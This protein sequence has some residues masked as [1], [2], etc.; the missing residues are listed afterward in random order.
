MGNAIL[1]L[2]LPQM[3]DDREQVATNYFFQSQQILLT[4]T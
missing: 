3:K 2:F 1:Y 4:L